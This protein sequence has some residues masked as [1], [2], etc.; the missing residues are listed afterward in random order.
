MRKRFLELTNM[1]RPFSVFR[2][3]KNCTDS[4]CGTGMYS[5]KTPDRYSKPL[6]A[7]IA[8]EFSEEWEKMA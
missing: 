3:A 1:A 2:V 4:P 6:E 7:E 8:H 5:H